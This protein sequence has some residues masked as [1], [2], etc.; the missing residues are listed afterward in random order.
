MRRGSRQT[1]SSKECHDAKYP[2]KSMYLVEECFTLFSD[3]K[4]HH[5]PYLP[6][7]AHTLDMDK[8]KLSDSSSDPNPTTSEQNEKAELDHPQRPAQILRKQSRSRNG[9]ASSA[10]TKPTLLHLGTSPPPTTN[11]SHTLQNFADYDALRQKHEDL[12]LEYKILHRENREADVELRELKRQNA[13]LIEAYTSIQ[14]EIRSPSPQETSSANPPSNIVGKLTKSERQKY[15]DCFTFLESKA[16]Y[17]CDEFKKRETHLSYLTKQTREAN[18]E[19]EG[20]EAENRKLSRRISDLQA[21]LTEARDELLGLQPA[22]LVSDAEVAEMCSDLGERIATWVDERTEDAEE[23]LEGYFEGVKGVEQLPGEVARVLDKR[24]LGVAIKKPEVLPLLIQHIVHARLKEEIFSREVLVYGLD[25]ANVM[26]LQG[27]EEGMG[28]LVPKR[29][30]PSRETGVVEVLTC[31]DALTIRRWRSETLQ[32][33][34]KMEAFA[35]EQ[36]RCGKAFA[37]NLASTLSTMLCAPSSAPLAWQSLHTSVIVPAVKLSNAI[38]IA[39][40][41]YTFFSHAFARPTER[42]YGVYRNEIQHHQML[43]CATQKMIRPDSTLKVD[44]HGRIGEEL[45]VISSGMLR[46]SKGRGEGREGHRGGERTVMVKP[47]M[48]VKLDEPMGRKKGS[49]PLGAWGFGW[50]GSSSEHGKAQ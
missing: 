29:G 26:L 37:E 35:E 49:K 4:T 2:K 27:I 44:E 43:D 21:Q 14:A 46:V 8:L 30:E 17:Y 18:S 19:K 20:A 42:P 33:L 15:H 23:V 12:R 25:E 7:Y 31:V 6:P 40:T 32:A 47:M 45:F 39:V 48:L 34:I 10:G 3:Q 16:D 13:Q 11:P 41:D 36:H 1:H 5:L 9:E 22:A 24:V 50:L 28:E 38:R